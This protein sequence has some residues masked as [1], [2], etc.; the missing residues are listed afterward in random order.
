[1]IN[2]KIKTLFCTFHSEQRNK[3]TYNFSKI[4]IFNVKIKTLF[5]T[6]GRC[7]KNI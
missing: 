2:V 5:W 7:K 6:L 3:C 1:M 4:I